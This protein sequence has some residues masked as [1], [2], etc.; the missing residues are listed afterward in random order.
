MVSKADMMK[1]IMKLEKI[2]F[3]K[4]EGFKGVKRLNEA[5]KE[6]IMIRCEDT[7]YYEI[8]D[9]FFP[10]TEDFKIFKDKTQQFWLVEVKNG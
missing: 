2:E 1:R 10:L 8:C 3:P 4:R 6:N 9:H 5:G 7:C